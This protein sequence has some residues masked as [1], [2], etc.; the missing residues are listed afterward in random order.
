MLGQTSF[1]FFK[2]PVSGHVKN[3]L[4]LN[5]EA[6]LQHGV[7]VCTTQVH[8]FSQ[9]GS[10]WISRPEVS[11]IPV[12]GRSLHRLKL[13][14]SRPWRTKDEEQVKC[15]RWGPG[16]GNRDTRDMPAGKRVY[17][18]KA[19]F[20]SRNKAHLFCVLV[21]TP[22]TLKYKRVFRI[23]LL[24]TTQRRVAGL[25]KWLGWHDGG[26]AST[27]PRPCVPGVGAAQP[28]AIYCCPV[29]RSSCTH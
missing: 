10:R 24:L 23:P 22:M 13:T 9:H 17:Q 19:A 29:P 14:A 6:Q 12:S 18:L 5:R 7:E 26:T 27:A 3:D 20:S 16:Q 28:R 8:S 25:G 11:T 4:Q 15:V 2:R 1:L 21:T